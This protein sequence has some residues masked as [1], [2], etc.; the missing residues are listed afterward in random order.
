LRVVLIAS[1]GELLGKRRA[2]AEDGTFP[3][4]YVDGENEECGNAGED[5][6]GVGKMVFTA[7]VWVVSI[8][9]FM[10][11]RGAYW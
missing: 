1:V 4:Y 9:C 11:G 7:D 3:V 8:T 5:R 10:K 2:F 6:G